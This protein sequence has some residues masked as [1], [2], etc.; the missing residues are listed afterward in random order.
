MDVSGSMAGDKLP[1]AKAA[2]NTFLGSM[3]PEDNLTLLAFNDRVRVVVPATNDPNA[4]RAGVDSLQPEGN[5]AAYD[6]LYRSAEILNTA[7]PDRRRVVVLLTDGADT[8]SR[9][10]SRVAA[11]V[12]QKS[13]ALVY[14]ISL[15][16]DAVDGV[17]KGLSEPTGGK[18]YKAPGPGDL[19]AIYRSIS[20]ELS[21][22]MRLRYAS[23]THVE[24]SYR[25][26]TVQMQYKDKAGQVV[27]RTIRYR[28]PPAALLA[29]TEISVVPTPSPQVVA[30]PSVVGPNKV[31]T[32]SQPPPASQSVATPL[33]YAGSALAG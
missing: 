20:L 22:Q 12:A 13:G 2:A 31:T 14:T 32:V 18:Y 27:V 1:Q 25:L 4:L 7:P 21:A 23:T 30:T 29:P 9:F 24:R 3:R 15:G 28:P 26:V 5:T 33:R 16:A 17:L 11:D 10:S 8:S 19:E 6:A